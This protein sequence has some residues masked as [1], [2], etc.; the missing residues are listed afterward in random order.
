[1]NQRRSRWVAR[2]RLNEKNEIS[3][4]G[5][6]FI[7]RV[8]QKRTLDGRLFQIAGAAERKP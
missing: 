1:M 4:V 7:V 2:K 3:G 8:S 6:M 5:G